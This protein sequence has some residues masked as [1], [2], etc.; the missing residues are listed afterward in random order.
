MIDMHLMRHRGVWTANVVAGAMGFAT[1]AAFGFVPQLLQ[2]PPEAGYGFG[3]TITES[4]F[5]LLPSAVA[6]FLVGF[7]T[8]RLVSWVGARVV[9]GTGLIVAGVSFLGIAF[10]HDE[11][12]Q[13]YAATRPGASG[14]A[15]CS[16]PSRA[17]SSRRGPT[18]QTGVANGVTANLRSS[19]ARSASRR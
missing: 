15:W 3:A 17:S 4:G 12:W 6:I 14:P 1:F 5:L 8:A 16:R 10:F 2:T 13:L 9:I 19:A 7:T 11:T 18:D